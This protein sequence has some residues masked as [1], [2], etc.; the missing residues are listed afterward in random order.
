[1]RINVEVEDF[2]P[3]VT[4]IWVREDGTLWVLP[5]PGE[6]DQPEGVM[7]TYDVF[8]AQGQFVRQVSLAC[9]GD[10]SEDRLILFAPGR[11]ALIRGAAD[12]RQNMFG[13]SADDGDEE[14]PVH[15][16]TIYRYGET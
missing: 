12:A 14:S 6:R 3:A 5:S 15:D 9:E 11:A 8:D 16:V 4:E 1:V 7:Q 10:P 2:A 13:H